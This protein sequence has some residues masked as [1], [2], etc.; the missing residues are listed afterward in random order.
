MKIVDLKFK[1]IVSAV[2]SVILV[3][4]YSY[5]S[6]YLNNV[7]IALEVLKLYLQYSLQNLHFQRIDHV[8]IRTLHVL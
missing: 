5:H 8:A 6:R 7:K 1:S 2:F 4:R 3:K